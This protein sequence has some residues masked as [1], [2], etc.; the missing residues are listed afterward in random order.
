MIRLT[1]LSG[2]QMTNPCLVGLDPHEWFWW[3]ASNFDKKGKVDYLDTI[4][5]FFTI[6]E[7]SKITFLRTGKKKQHFFRIKTLLCRPIPCDMKSMIRQKTKEI[8]YYLIHIPWY[9]IINQAH[10]FTIFF[11]WHFMTNL[12]KNKTLMRWSRSRRSII[13]LCFYEHILRIYSLMRGRICEEW[14]Q[15]HSFI[16]VF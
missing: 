16:H 14:R 1:I 3:F 7:I 12:L 10:T 5:G 13:R 9:N 6:I 8:P 2:F 11:I 4:K 15:S